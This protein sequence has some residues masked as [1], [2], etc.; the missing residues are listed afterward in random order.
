ME[1]FV[2]F[3]HHQRLSGGDNGGV[4]GSR[5]LVERKNRQS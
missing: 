2:L 5:P 4:K 3:V 1:S